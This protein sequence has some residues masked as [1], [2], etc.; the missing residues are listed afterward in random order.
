MVSRLLSTLFLAGALLASSG[1]WS[2]AF[3]YSWSA[4]GIVNLPGPNVRLTDKERNIVGEVPVEQVRQLLRIKDDLARVSG[5]QGELY[6]TDGRD[7]NAFATRHNGKNLIGVNLAMLERFSNDPDALAAVMGH[8]LAHLHKNHGQEAQTRDAVLGVLGVLAGLALDYKLNR[9]YGAS[10]DLGLTAGTTGA[11]LLARKFD[12]DQEREADAIGLQ[13]VA[14]AGYDPNGAVR[15]WQSMGPSTSGLFMSTHP[16]HGERIDLLRAQIVQLPP[17]QRTATARVAIR[18]P[19]AST[20]AAT[21]RPQSAALAAEFRETDSAEDDPALLAMR[22]ISVRQ[23]EEAFRHALSSA[24]QGDPRGQ[25]MLGHLYLNGYGTTRDPIQ[26]ERYLRL[27]ADQESLMAATMLGIMLESGTVRAR[28]L[29]AAVALYE[30]AAAADFPY[31]QAR[32]ANLKFLGAGVAKDVPGATALALAAAGSVQDGFTYNLL[33]RIAMSQ[34]DFPVARG[35]FQKG[36]ALG[37]APSQTWLG[38]LYATG[39]GVERNYSEAIRY[40]QA[41]IT[42]G[43]SDAKTGMGYLYLRGEGVPRDTDRA[44]GLFEEAAQ[45]RNSAALAALGQIY[46]DG[47]GVARDTAKA[48]AY[49]DLAAQ[50]GDAGARSAREAVRAQMGETEL[51]RAGQLAAEL[52]R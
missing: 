32:L 39:R 22:A 3:K 17:G 1:A 23:Y 40:Y 27:A 5:L 45:A 46:R 29:P 33:G 36:A 13:W 20:A 8:E 44:R 16:S 47:I 26:A 10:G 41:A 42:K 4:N 24:E 43:N 6:I 12:R 48:Y 21:G 38:I 9:R 7:P 52:R 35:W 51:Q 30:K 19:D 28:D 37:F 50:H 34:A 15:L 14:A 49:F 25:F 11:G 18:V 31:A 2:Q